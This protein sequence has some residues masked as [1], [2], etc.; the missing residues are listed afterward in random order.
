MLN[1]EFSMN[2]KNDFLQHLKSCPECAQEFEAMNQ[3]YS[4]LSPTTKM[5]STNLLKTKIMHKI[6]CTDK[7]VAQQNRINSRRFFL[8]VSGIAAVL[9]VA[10][11]LIVFLKPQFINQ[12]NAA[13]TLLDKSIAALTK[14]TTMQMRFKVRS[15]PGEDFDLLDL[16]TDLI[17]YKIIK[18]FSDP[19]K[20]RIE[21]P[22]LTAVMDGEK[23]Y[24][25]SSITGLGYLA[26][27]DA[28]LVSWMRIFLDPEKILENEKDFSA[29][30]KAKYE[31]K[32]S[33]AEKILTIKTDALGDFKNPYLLNKSFMGS[34]NRRVYHFDINT[35]RL[36][37]VEIYVEDKGKEI[38][39]LETSEITYDQPVSDAVFVVN[40]TSPGIKWIDLN[41]TDR[42][43]SESIIPSNAEGVSELWW[44]SI[45]DENWETA[46]KLYLDIEKS[47]NYNEF[48]AVYGGL[49]IIKLG[50]A[51]K[52]GQYP[53]VFIPYE[54]ELKSGEKLTG[55]LALRNDNP[56]KRWVIDGG[57]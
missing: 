12:A 2:E 20:W 26:K 40:I 23:L 44:N 43:A 47:N 22:E 13:Q 7:T 50:K 14:I 24:R 32:K 28:G 49:K 6:D 17:E 29:R 54:V 35:D 4:A 55:N 19:Q 9:I 8:R 25:Y 11:A 5:S 36:E 45:A 10:L 34:K 57:L 56:D 21:K 52:S 48:K 16:N 46:Q 1:L 27:T 33:G 51:F 30:H 39:V 42:L 15:L 37:A 53:G 18:Q 41:K 3:V 31:I 38:L